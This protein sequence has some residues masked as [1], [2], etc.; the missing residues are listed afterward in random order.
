M[1]E[2]LSLPD[3][4]ARLTE[5]I[6]RAAAGEEIIISQDGRPMARLVPLPANGPR[7]PG[8]WAHLRGRIDDDALLAPMDE[9]DLDAAEGRG[10]DGFG[11]SRG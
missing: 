3:A 4:K 7:R 2:T 6:N 8:A 10:T 11:L 9:E 5:L 1:S